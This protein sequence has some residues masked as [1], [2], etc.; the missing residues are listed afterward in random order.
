MAGKTKMKRSYRKKSG[1]ARGKRG[2]VSASVKKYVNRIIHMDQEN[3]VVNFNNS[4]NFGNTFANASLYSYP[5][6]PYT[7][8]GTIG[9]GITAGG[10]IGNEIKLRKVML[11]YVLRPNPYDITNNPFPMPVE[12]EMYLGRTRAVPG[13]IPAVSDFNNLFQ[14]GS[15]AFGP[16]GNLSDL[17]SDTNNDYWTIKKRWR[18][19]V[20]NGNYTGTGPSA[21]SQYYN[22]NDFKLNIVKKLDITKLCPKTLKFN[23][24]NNSV[25]GAGLFFFYQALSAGGA[26]N[27]SSVLPCHID[28]WIDIHYEDA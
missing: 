1:V 8:F 12:V 20:G 21:G 10:R 4:L 26:T 18:H 14:S 9:Q 13:E 16:T 17:I 25:Q 15:S 7:G 28:Y 24:S 22:N 23:D 5:I 11:K 27:G 3:K 2:S 6:L 19:K